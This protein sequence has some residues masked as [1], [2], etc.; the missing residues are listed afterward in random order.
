MKLAILATIMI[1]CLLMT[2]LGASADGSMTGTNE[3]P[4][5]TNT[6]KFTEFL[7]NPAVSELDGEF[8]ELRNAGNV[9]ADIS[10]WTLSDQDGPMDMIF[11]NMTISPG[12]LVVVFSGAGNNS[13]DTASRTHWLYMN[14]TTSAWSNTGDDLLLCDANG[15]PVDY[16]SYGDGRG[17]DPL[18]RDA[19]LSEGL[20]ENSQPREINLADIDEGNSYSLIGGVWAEAVPSPGNIPSPATQLSDIVISQICPAVGDDGEFAAIENRGPTSV[21]IGYFALTDGEG[22]AAFPPGTIIAS[23]QTLVIAKNATTYEGLTHERPDFSYGINMITPKSPPSLSNNGDE[24]FFIAPDL[25]IIDAV[26]Y[27]DSE[28]NGEAWQG[29]AAA[30]PKKAQILKR[31]AGPDTDTA[32]DWDDNSTHIAGQTSFDTT[33]MVA[34]GSITAFLSPDCAMNV[35]Q[36]VLA[37]ATKNIRI[38]IYE[39][40]N[41]KLGEILIQAEALGVNVTLFVEGEPV[42]GLNASQLNFMNWLVNGGVDVRLHI[43]NEK[44]PA[45]R[46]RF[47]HAK[48][49]IIDDTSV[50]VLTEN[51]GYTG[52]PPAGHAGNRGWGAVIRN[53]T[54]AAHYSALFDADSNI[55]WHD[56]ETLASAHNTTYNASMPMAGPGKRQA[57]IV[58]EFGSA[59]IEGLFN[60]TPI[61][62]P[63]QTLKAGDPVLSMLENATASV[64]VEQFYIDTSWENG[65]NPYLEAVIDAARRGCDVRVLLDASFYNTRAADRNDNDDT[66][67]YINTLARTENLTL[68]AKL[69]R[70]DGHTFTKIHAKGMVVDGSQTLISSINW[71]KNS[72]TRN[73]EV[74]VIIENADFASYFTTS[75]ESDWLDRVHDPRPIIDLKGV[76]KTGQNITFSAE[77]STA[78]SGIDARWDM[79][80]DGKVDVFDLT[81]AWAYK[82]PGQYIVTLEIE[83]IWGNVNST[84]LMIEIGEGNAPE[85]D[86]DG[87]ESD[88]EPVVYIST[89]GTDQ[90]TLTVVGENTTAREI[91]QKDMFAAVLLLIP[92][93]L[94]VGVSALRKLQSGLNK[95]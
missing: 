93:M 24:L 58:P 14:K 25:T 5:A 2:G 34:K 70:P 92:M 51:W 56:V 86:A 43:S 13:Y 72:I 42:G 32:G 4:S 15:T 69:V 30:K 91:T 35:I 75:F 36:E 68:T 17:V 19:E 28:Y 40:Y 48:Y 82:R 65:P 47:N 87:D 22:R 27:G 11:R 66:V 55:C 76:L 31:K 12:G 63:D 77:N 62:A 45:D 61:I 57:V 59:T 79:D 81:F 10:G 89:R 73:R 78:S 21:D 46:Y 84:S 7:Y 16:V 1:V 18:P 74:G 83:D 80:G 90:R 29:P 3:V 37:N 71:N 41:I 67:R 95:R 53:K 26:C 23:N 52:I 8:V 39:F 88:D 9:T 38:N 44:N 50:I 94:V 54:V 20:Q 64:L 49:M 85:S 6:V 60:I 33:T